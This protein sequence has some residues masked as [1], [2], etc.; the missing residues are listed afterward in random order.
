MYIYIYIY[1]F[2]HTTCFHIRIK[3]VY[4]RG[5]PSP[6]AWGLKGGGGGGGVS[7]PGHS[8]K[9]RINAPILAHAQTIL[10]TSN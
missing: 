10:Y 9:Q 1:I 7:P 3:H 4:L 5:V 8:R 6:R 2:I